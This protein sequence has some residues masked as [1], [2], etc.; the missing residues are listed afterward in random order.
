MG[1]AQELESS[2]MRPTPRESL[3]E[4]DNPEEEE[5]ASGQF[6]QQNTSNISFG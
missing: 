6:E 3:N 2:I 1:T 4:N 5:Q